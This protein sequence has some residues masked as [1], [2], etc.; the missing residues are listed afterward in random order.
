MP[1]RWTLSKLFLGALQGARSDNGGAADVPRGRAAAVQGGQRP[2][3]S[4]HV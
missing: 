1:S 2:R 4:V 3:V